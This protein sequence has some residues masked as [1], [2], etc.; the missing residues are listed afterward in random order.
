MKTSGNG[1]SN[2]ALSAYLDQELLPED[3]QALETRLGDDPALREDLTSLS[4]ATELCRDHLPRL[5]P[6]EELWMSIR[7]EIDGSFRKE[8]TSPRRWFGWGALAATVSVGILV[9]LVI[10]PPAVRPDSI[11]ARFEEFIQTRERVELQ[12]GVAS[13]PFREAVDLNLNPFASE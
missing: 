11:R 3:A 6:D 10:R 5:E 13:N 9:L 7:S 4:R 1:S 2:E 12:M 8:P